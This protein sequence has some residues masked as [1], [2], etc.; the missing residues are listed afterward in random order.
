[1]ILIQSLCLITADIRLH[2]SFRAVRQG[3]FALRQSGSPGRQLSEF[4]A[5]FRPC[6][7]ERPAGDMFKAIQNHTFPLYFYVF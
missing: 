5:Y 6:R 1:M 7:A 4:R 2:E 3:I